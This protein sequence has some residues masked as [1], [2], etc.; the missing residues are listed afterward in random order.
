MT[1]LLPFLLIVAESIQ[2]I[3]G[4]ESINEEY[5]IPALVLAVAVG[6]LLDLTIDKG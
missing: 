4:V 3:R 6:L 5:R 1:F 2:A